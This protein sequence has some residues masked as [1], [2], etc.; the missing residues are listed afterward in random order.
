MKSFHIALVVTL[1][2][3]LEPVSARR[4]AEVVVETPAANNTAAAS[5]D[6]TSWFS[7]A[8]RPPSRKEVEVGLEA[9]WKQLEE[10][11]SLQRS[12]LS[13]HMEEVS[14]TSKEKIEEL[15]ENIDKTRKHIKRR[16]EADLLKQKRGWKRFRNSVRAQTG[17]VL[18]GA[19]TFA[20]KTAPS[21]QAAQ[22]TWGA[23]D[24]YNITRGVHEPW[25]K[26]VT[27]GVLAVSMVVAASGE[28]AE[29]SNLKQRTIPLMTIG[30][31]IVESVGRILDKFEGDVT[32]ITRIAVEAVSAILGTAVLSL[33]P[34]PIG[35]VAAS[36]AGSTLLFQGLVEEVV[37]NWWALLERGS[38]SFEKMDREKRRKIEKG[39][40][41]QIYHGLEKKLIYPVRD[42]FDEVH[43][44][45]RNQTLEE[46][47]LQD[48]IH[49]AIQHS[50][51]VKLVW[52][53]ATAGIVFQLLWRTK[54]VEHAMS[55]VSSWFG[56][57][58]TRSSHPKAVKKRRTG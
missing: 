53:C 49:E 36:I 8:F 29:D 7:Y 31:A 55:S 5:T 39:I 11:V 12:R 17:I 9:R 44:A 57:I 45:L 35:V 30:L 26:D 2:L 16:I 41:T 50:L 13:Q 22:I 48:K 15:D 6:W 10:D 38:R 21:V 25:L 33:I 47:S 51:K 34:L 27:A 28:S 3:H 24:K 52:S 19:M 4:K 42:V 54:P 56:G 14:R 40:R 43:A 20:G 18:G 58:T 46:P 32:P 37:G 23:L 1:L